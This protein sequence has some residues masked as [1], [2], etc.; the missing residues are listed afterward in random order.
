MFAVR[1]AISASAH[2]GE[3]VLLVQSQADADRKSAGCLTCHTSTDS[4]T[5]HATGT[6]RLGC[7][8]CHGGNSDARIVA[9]TPQKSAGYFQVKK[10]AHPQPR[11]PDAARS[12]AN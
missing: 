10:Q 9:D 2:S 7:T 8:D 4:P 11:N 5:M 6:V 1:T 3:S 12:S